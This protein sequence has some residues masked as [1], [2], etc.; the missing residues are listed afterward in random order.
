MIINNIMN[1]L[2]C[3]IEIFKN[4]SSGYPEDFISWKPSPDK[5]CILEI[6]NHLY[7]EER[8]D[9]RARLKNILEG[10]TEWAPIKPA[11]WV[12]ERKY[13]ERNFG[14]SLDNFILERNKSINWLKTINDSDLDK[15]VSHPKFGDF[16]A[17]QMLACW[18]THDM[19][20]IRQI[21]KLQYEYLES[22][23]KPY[24]LDYAGGW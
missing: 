4:I 1:S 20:H 9:F 6:I 10:S 24:T 15:T 7:D 18:L 16:N 3:N 22:S 17:R 5:W 11:E 14:E 13:I 2:S 19:L 8:E 21:L 12:T 23:I